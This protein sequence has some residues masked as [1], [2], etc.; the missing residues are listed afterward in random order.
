[1][2]VS[3]GLVYNARKLARRRVEG[4]Y[5]EQYSSLQDYAEELKASNSG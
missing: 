1:M 3:S 4:S 5:E 2:D